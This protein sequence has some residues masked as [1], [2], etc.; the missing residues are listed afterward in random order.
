MPGTRVSLDSL[1]TR[2]SLLPVP[3]AC[4]SAARDGYVHVAGEVDL[5]STPQLERALEAALSQSLAVVLDLQDVTF[6]DSGGTRAIVTASVRAR[7]RGRRLVLLR[8]PP[9]VDRLFTLT[10]LRDQVEFFQPG[11]VAPAKRML[12]PF[13]RSRLGRRRAQTFSGTT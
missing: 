1:A 2:E 13:R 11:S 7:T 6:L 9:N 3:F 4:T 5:A 8:G 12:A 10:H